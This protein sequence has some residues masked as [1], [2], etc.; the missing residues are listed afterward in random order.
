EPP[1]PL[2]EDTPADLPS[3][4]DLP[5]DP[6]PPADLGLPPH[7]VDQGVVPEPPQAG[8]SDD[9]GDVLPEP[10]G[11]A[12]PAGSVVP[13]GQ[14]GGPDVAD[15]DP[16]GVPEVDLG[17]ATDVDLGGELPP[18]E[19]PQPIDAGAPPAPG[20]VDDG[21]I[22][23]PDPP[24]GTVDAPGSVVP[25]GQPGGEADV[26]DAPVS[27]VP[28][29]QP[30][31]DP[32]GGP[33]GDG[34][35]PVDLGG[36]L[37]PHEQPQ[38]NDGGAPPAPGATDGGPVELPDPADPVPGMPGTDVAGLQGGAQGVLP[39]LVDPDAA[40]AVPA[41]LLAQRGIVTAAGDDLV[42]QID[43]GGGTINGDVIILGKD[44][45]AVFPVK[46]ERIDGDSVVV[47]DTRNAQASAIPRA[48]FRRM[49]AEAGDRTVS[50]ADLARLTEFVT[51]LPAPEPLTPTEP[52]AAEEPDGGVPMG[53]VVAAAVALPLVV[54][55]G[56]LAAR[57]IRG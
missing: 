21:T 26:V 3:A 54:G 37:P 56:Y 15:V 2:M 24:D 49:W 5:P 45:E 8:T 43:T 9:G 38:A 51:P 14:P 44:A 42:V 11:T 16:G 22:E 10:P 4:P 33:A 28:P 39:T 27:M 17:G 36:E 57:R 40:T 34:P 31:G 18:H 47:R 19:Q 1:S 23:L 41:D 32:T 25:P 20:A 50:G 52:I 7:E 29:G 55:G 53:L 12:D 46:V 13:L 48:E 30:G 35:A 6:E